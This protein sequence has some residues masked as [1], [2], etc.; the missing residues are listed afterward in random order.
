ML[1][2]LAARLRQPARGVTLIE[3]MFTLTVMG[4]LLGLAA[5]SFMGW[6]RNNQVR[7]VA[8]SVQ[9]GIRAA[10]NAAVQR[11][12]TVVFFLTNA[13]PMVGAPAAAGAR[14]WAVQYVPLPMDSPVAPEPFLV[15][16]RMAEA[17]TSNVLVSATAGGAAI[18]A[19]CFNSSGRLVTATP[20]TNTVTGAMCT[21]A[22]ATFDISSLNGGDRPLRVTVDLSGR[23]RMCDP[24]RPASA[25]D[26]C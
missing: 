5:P 26:G 15:G 25:P 4:V 12:R 1:P 2:V 7:S 13:T 22:P 3:L 9:T 14:N 17:G 18:G 21:A 10:H 8:E 6:I 19:L 20:A 11:N 24:A 23:V 16:A